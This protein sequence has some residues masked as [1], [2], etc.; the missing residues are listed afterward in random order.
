MIITQTP[1]RISFVGGGTDFGDFYRRQNGEVIST[2]IDKY[3][4]VIIKERFDSQIYLNYSKKEIVDCVDRIEHE[5]IREAMRKTGVAQGVEITTLADIPAHGSGLGSSS[6]VTIGVLNALYAYQ[7]IGKTA[8]DLAQEACK[9]EI[10]VLGKPIGKQDQYIAAY[11]GLRHIQFQSDESVVV[12]R[13]PIS[14]ETKRKLNTNTLLFYTGIERKASDI[15]TEQRQNIDQNFE[16]LCEMK[17]LVR[18]LKAVLTNHQ[19]N[20]HHSLDEFGSLLHQG[21]KLKQH[22]AS[23]I[24]NPRLNEIYDAAFNA[25]AL[26]GKLLGA[27]GGGFFLF[28]APPETHDDIRVALHHLQEFPFNLERDGSKVIFNIRR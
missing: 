18:K 7:G 4:Y 9:I 28:Y 13:V 20:G 17:P 21:W 8:E 26:G 14:E 19:N 16:V 25:G 6:C 5:L 2:A 23:T 27:G 12:E 10:Q 11:G 22:L 24:S 1:L 3:V 15:L